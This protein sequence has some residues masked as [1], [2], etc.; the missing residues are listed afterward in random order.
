MILLNDCDEVNHDK[1]SAIF[2]THYFENILFI[3]ISSPTKQA[4]ALRINNICRQ[5]NPQTVFFLS[6]TFGIEGWFISDFGVDFQHK[7]DPPNDKKILK[8]TFPSLQSVF[9]Q[10]WGAAISRFFPLSTTYVKSRVLREFITAENRL[11]VQSEAD[12]KTLN[13]IAVKKLAS[14]KV[15]ESFLAKLELGRFPSICGS[16][17]SMACSILGSYLAQEVIKGVSL[18]GVPGFNIFELNGDDCSVRAFPFGV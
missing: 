13:E 18:S 2:L 14:N 16:V 4:E 6:G 11:P 17:N 1:P 7:G 15:D 12:L 8:T 10:S 3:L 5:N 9:N